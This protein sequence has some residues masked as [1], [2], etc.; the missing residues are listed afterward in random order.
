M[1]WSYVL[2]IL[3]VLFWG[4]APIF[5]KIALKDA[6]PLSG[7]LVRSVAVLAILLLSSVF[8]N[9]SFTNLI[10]IPPKSILFFVLSGIFAGFLGMVTYYS[11][12]KSLPSS[13][14]VPL[15]SIYPLVTAM[16]G[17]FILAEGFSLL[18]LL[19]VVLIVL[20]IWFIRL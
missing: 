1:N 16:L 15:C 7:L 14:A 4:L 12:L 20:G 19:G 13:V 10:K 11:A 18:R 9:N 3:T 6:H 5:D 2:I 17:M 8:I